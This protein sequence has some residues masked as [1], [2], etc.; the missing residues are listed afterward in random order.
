MGTDQQDMVIQKLD[1]FTEIP[2]IK[3]IH[4]YE[5]SQI[6]TLYLGCYTTHCTTQSLF[7]KNCYGKSLIIF[8]VST[9]KHNENVKRENQQDATI[10]CLLSTSV[11]TCFGHHYAHL[12]EKVTVRLVKQ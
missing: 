1:G 12:Q 3:N 10:R 5:K 8:F 7:S 6:H 9:V 11:S 4:I 2:Y